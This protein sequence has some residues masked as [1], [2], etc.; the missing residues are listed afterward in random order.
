MTI[1]DNSELE[2]APLKVL[3][4]G[5]DYD[6]PEI[7]RGVEVITQEK[8]IVGRFDTGDFQADIVAAKDFI[9][10]QR[11][12]IHFDASVLMHFDASINDY[13]QKQPETEPKQLRL[14]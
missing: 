10:S 9:K 1:I 12:L 14:L 2:K 3:T 6:Y 7:Y 8:K 4:I 5:I 13:G 11:G